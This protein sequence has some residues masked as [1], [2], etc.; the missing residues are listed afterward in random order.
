MS[1]GNMPSALPTARRQIL[2]SVGA[3]AMAAVIAGTL[4]SSTARAEERPGPRGFWMPGA[5]LSVQTRSAADVLE[6]VSQMVDG[7]KAGTG[8]KLRALLA[9]GL[10]AGEA[11]ALDLIGG[12]RPAGLLVLNPRRHEGHVVIAVGDAGLQGVFRALGRAIGQEIDD[13]LIEFGDFVIGEG[14]SALYFRH[15]A[16]WVVCSLAPAPLDAAARAIKKGCVP[17]A[18]RRRAHVAAHLDMNELRA[19]YGDVVIG[20]FQI[21]RAAMSAAAMQPQ[22]PGNPMGPF[23]A[24]IVKEYINAGE[25]IFKGFDEVDLALRLSGKAAEIEF[26]MLPSEEGLFA[27]LAQVAEPATFAPAMALPEDG[28]FVWAWRADPIGTERLIDAF[29]RAAVRVSTNRDALDEE[30]EETREKIA[31]CRRLIG[32]LLSGESASCVVMSD[33]GMGSV[34]AMDADFDRVREI[35]AEMAEI[36]TTD[37]A[38]LFDNMGFGIKQGYEKDVRALA[39]GGRV[40]RLTT[41]YKF[42]GM[43][44]AQMKGMFDML[45]GG[46]KQVVEIGDAAPLTVIGWGSDDT[47]KALDEAVERARQPR[48]ID[49]TA[50]PAAS[51]ELVRALDKARG[52]V[53]MAFEVRMGGYLTM[54]MSMMKAQPGVGDVFQFDDEDAEKLL[55]KDVPIVGWAGA[56]DARLLLYERI[57][58]ASV[59]NVIEFFEKMRKRMMERMGPMG[60][61]H[62]DWEEPEPGPEDP[63]EVW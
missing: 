2:T 61:G 36:I 55:K 51:K 60:G 25:A 21:A 34:M 38:P 13:D 15:V 19:A 26:S 49:E 6:A 3:A 40:D 48:D 52:V 45:F 11:D 1:R 12:E 44:A 28:T 31:N 47:A 33:K 39:G 58:T 14:D 5:F 50:W 20:A 22:G 9:Q 8:E 35:Y 42:E 37:L 17:R 62:D 4:A 29:A 56:E 53:T 41:T 24:S 43:M 57:P 16:P 23:A 46:D 27:P 63:V 59:K 54:V 32:G 10:A 30:D 7:V 18:P